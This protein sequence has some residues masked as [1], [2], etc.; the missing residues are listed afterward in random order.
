MAWSRGRKRANVRT[1]REIRLCRPVLR[2]NLIIKLAL[3][4]T[5]FILGAAAGLS[6]PLIFGSLGTP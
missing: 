1:A 2:G 5:L 4:L 6:Y 3:F